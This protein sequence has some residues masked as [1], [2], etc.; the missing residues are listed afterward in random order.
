M[1]PFGKN[2]PGDSKTNS[3]YIYIP[4]GENRASSF[5]RFEKM[6]FSP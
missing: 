6:P 1:M 2:V 5:E 4:S 3:P